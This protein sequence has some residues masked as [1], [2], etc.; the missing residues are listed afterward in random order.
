MNRHWERAHYSTALVRNDVEGSTALELRR[1]D[2]GVVA[3]LVFWDAAGQ[4]YLDSVH[5]ELPLD[6]VAELIAE[7][8]ASIPVK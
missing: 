3:R 6:I 4:F 5:G 1:G 8:R 7:A 2:A